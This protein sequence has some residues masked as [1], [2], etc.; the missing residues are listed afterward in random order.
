MKIRVLTHTQWRCL[1][2]DPAAL[3]LHRGGRY[4]LIDEDGQWWYVRRE[5][6][7]R[8]SS[9]GGLEPVDIVESVP[10]VEINEVLPIGAFAGAVVVR[11]AEVC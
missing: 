9:G 1:P 11:P 7:V 2:I 5:R 6:C 8:R 4:R 3:S 10:L